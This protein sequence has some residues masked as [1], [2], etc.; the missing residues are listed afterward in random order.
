MP[1]HVSAFEMLFAGVGQ[2]QPT[3]LCLSNTV[4]QTSLEQVFNQ[5][6]AEAEKL[7]EGRIDG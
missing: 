1:W 4:S 5:H 3:N 7:K 2:I 6:A